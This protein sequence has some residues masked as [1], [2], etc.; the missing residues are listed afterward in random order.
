M[1]ALLLAGTLVV[2]AGVLAIVFGIPIKEFSFGNT[3]IICGA[4]V[5]ST[6]LIL[7][8]L[9]ILAREVK[10]LSRRLGTG[11]VREQVDVEEIMLAEVPAP[12]PMMPEPPRP[13]PSRS[14]GNSDIMIAPDEPATKS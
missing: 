9:G 14:P 13:A 11:P 5:A 1:I 2:C 4:V 6:G 3:M 10:Q 8:G 12:A 7:I